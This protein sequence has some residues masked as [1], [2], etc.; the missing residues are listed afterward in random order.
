MIK[1]NSHKEELLEVVK[2]I[3]LMLT[4][5]EDD[6]IIRK[7]PA[8]SYIKEKFESSFVGLGLKNQHRVSKDLKLWHQDAKKWITH[9]NEVL[10][11]SVDNP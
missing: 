8:P 7:L 3:I 11:V 4:D 6:D 9:R 2:F 10:G 5:V 1:T